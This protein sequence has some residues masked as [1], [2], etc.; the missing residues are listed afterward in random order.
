MNNRPPG[1]EEMAELIRPC[2][3]ER[4]QVMV[5]TSSWSDRHRA[6]L[7]DVTA[8]TKSF[9]IQFIAP[10]DLIHHLIL[11]GEYIIT[12]GWIPFWKESASNEGIREDDIPSIISRT[13]KQVV[14]LDTGIS[15]EAESDLDEVC[16]KYGLPYEIIPVG[17]EYLRLV[18]SEALHE[19][20]NGI[21]SLEMTK[22][23][24]KAEAGTALNA[25]TLSL[26]GEMVGI[27]EEDLVITRICNIIEMITGAQEIRYMHVA[28]GEI[29][30]P[31]ACYGSLIEPE[32]VL[33]ETR[34]YL[35][36]DWGFLENKDGL[37][38]VV[39]SGNEPVGVCIAG[40]MPFPENMREYLNIII[41]L[42]DIFGLI[43]T[44]VRISGQLRKSEARYR[45][46]IEDQTEIIC[47]FDK[48]G[49]VLYANDVFCRFFGVTQEEIRRTRWQLKAYSEDIPYIK[50]KLELLTPKNPVVMID[51]RVITG[52]GEL[53]WMQFV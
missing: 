49:Q 7:P 6:L 22:R 13:L 31:H 35:H 43:I 18:I 41:P 17:T 20:G 21:Q 3:E 32:K 4:R 5:F 40:S 48:T 33:E 23:L 38:F 45:G 8:I 34:Q 1:A 50:K 42:A 24:R 51:N 52:D 2:L 26:I 53:R 11:N 28:E 12:P 14:L 36:L 47:R 44:K 46:L 30:E 9:C 29:G 19:A 15:P 37:F 10:P 39:R 16:S 27:E 25:M